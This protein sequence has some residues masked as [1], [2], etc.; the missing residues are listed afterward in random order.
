[1]EIKG[2]ETVLS[3]PEMDV[4]GIKNGDTYPISYMNGQLQ[5][6]GDELSVEIA[7]FMNG[8]ATKPYVEMLHKRKLIAELS[9]QILAHELDAMQF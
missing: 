8:C 5:A 9:G 4:L 6:I 3:K 1:V 2:S 7:R